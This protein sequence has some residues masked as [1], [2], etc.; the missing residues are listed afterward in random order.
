M[1]KK[2]KIVYLGMVEIKT[3]YLR[4]IEGK[5]VEGMRCL[6]AHFGSWNKGNFEGEKV[7]VGEVEKR[8]A[9]TPHNVNAVNFFVSIYSFER[10]KKRLVSDWGVNGRL[11][12]SN[13]LPYLFR[14]EALK[15]SN[16]KKY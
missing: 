2:E 1:L 9:N 14:R 11:S 7:L 4:L 5:R 16:D 10:G 3:K 13:Q 6:E 12:G 15:L 8:P